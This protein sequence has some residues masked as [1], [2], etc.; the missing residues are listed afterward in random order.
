MPAMISER[1]DTVGVEQD[2]QLEAR[3]AIGPGARGGVVVCHPHPLYGGDMDNP[4]VVRIAEVCG[5]LGLATLRFNFRGVGASTGVHDGG[6][7]ERR[8]VEAA[9]DHL[10]KLLPDPDAVALAGYSFGA[11]VAAQVAVHGR[12]LRGVALV[13][14]A[15]AFAGLPPKLADFPQ[16]LLVVG[17]TQDEY[18]PLDALDRLRATLP[19]ATVS[20]IDGANHFFFGRLFPLGQAVEPWAR[21]LV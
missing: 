3:L 9:L 19:R 7:G 2:V 10:A 8:D 12:S 6:A 21:E 13:A 17:G 15:L 14:P 16:P 18:C 11:G 4:V 20:V 1:E 5:A